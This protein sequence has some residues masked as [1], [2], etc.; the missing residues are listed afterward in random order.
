[1]PKIAFF[2]PGAIGEPMARRLLQAGFTVTSAIHRSRTAAD[3]LAAIGLRIA[4]NMQDAVT[5]A[6]IVIAVLPTDAEVRDVLLES[7]FMRTLKR[8]AIII[9][10][11]S[12]QAGTV[13]EVA[14]AYKPLGVHVIDAPV[15][16]GV[17][18]AE[19]GTL[20]IFG[21]GEHSVLLA[22]RPVLDA[23][24]NKIHDLGKL[25]NG[26]TIKNLN[27]LMQIINLMG[28]AE[29]FHVLRAEGIDPDLFFDV[30]KTSSGNSSSFETRFKRMVTGTDASGFKIGLARKDVANALEINKSVPMP[31][32]HL[33]HQ[34]M[35]AA[36]AWDDLDITAVSRLFDQPANP[37]QPSGPQKPSG[38]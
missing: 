35:L 36:S 21:S 8:D 15:S 12:C 32:S 22:V 26:K 30:V 18:G 10:M 19:T 3:A 23:M 16:G 24:G 28:V 33:A 13:R 25:G 4:P 14:Q 27:N 6:D 38:T 20:T 1:M 31:V 37:A 34:L 5:D 2:G 7:R 11:S 29:V 17:K 9:E